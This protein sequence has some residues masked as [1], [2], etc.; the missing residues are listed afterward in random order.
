MKHSLTITVFFSL[1]FTACT[2]KEETIL[3][4]QQLKAK[5]D[6]IVAMK[7]ADI[8]QQAAEDLDRRSSIEVKAKADSIVEAWQ[9]KQPKAQA[10]S[11]K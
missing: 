3:T 7:K 5:A 6:S 1:F 4:K 2:R 11:T 10:D 8:S 9:A